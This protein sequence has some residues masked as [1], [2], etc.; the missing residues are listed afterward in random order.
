VEDEQFVDGD[1]EGVD[2]A[3]DDVETGVGGPAFDL[4][5]SLSA[6]AGCVGESGLRKSGSG[7]FENEIPTEELP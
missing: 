3:I 2:D 6:K 4:G 5:D 7:S 1:T